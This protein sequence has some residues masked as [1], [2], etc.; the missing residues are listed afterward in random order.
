MVPGFRTCGA[1]EAFRPRELCNSSLCRCGNN[2]NWD[3]TATDLLSLLARA[4][5]ANPVL[6]VDIKDSG[7]VRDARVHAI[8][9]H[10]TQGQVNSTLACSE[11]V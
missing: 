3:L 4:I 11:S 10:G 8:A 9:V 5:K 7:L 6:T 1:C 2:C